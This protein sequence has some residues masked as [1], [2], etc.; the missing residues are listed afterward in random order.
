MS[1]S[2]LI[3]AALIAVF[4]LATSPVKANTF[5]ISD[6]CL[7]RTVVS[8]YVAR[9]YNQSLVGLAVAS[10]GIFQGSVIEIWEPPGR[11]TWTV[12]ATFPDG[13][14]CVLAYGNNW[15]DMRPAPAK[16]T[17]RPL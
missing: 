14:T 12:I 8:D 15:Q 5:I 9:N 16:P 6:K 10:A 2:R 11:E 4:F 1:P 17:G 3:Q 7:P 13:V